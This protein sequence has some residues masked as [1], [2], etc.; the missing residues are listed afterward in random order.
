MFQENISKILNDVTVNV[1]IMVV[2]ISTNWIGVVEIT[3]DVIN[4]R[5]LRILCCGSVTDVAKWAL[6]RDMSNT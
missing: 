4:V 3:S 5:F 2:V 1:V 6:I